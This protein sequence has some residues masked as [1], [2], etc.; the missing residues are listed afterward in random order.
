MERTADI[1]DGRHAERVRRGLAFM[2]QFPPH[3]G[4]SKIEAGVARSE[5]PAAPVS[6]TEA[7]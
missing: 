3:D 2:A 7:A 4:G 1:E 6:L 5:G